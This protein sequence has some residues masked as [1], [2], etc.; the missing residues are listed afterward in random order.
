MKMTM[1]MMDAAKNYL[2]QAGPLYRV[3]QMPAVW[4][5]LEVQRANPGATWCAHDAMC[6][7]AINKVA[8]LI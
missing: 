7:A 6:Q 2:Q 8:T 4:L 3:D 5:S 1:Q